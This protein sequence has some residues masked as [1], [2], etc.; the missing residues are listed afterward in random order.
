M[1]RLQ[2]IRFRSNDREKYLGKIRKS[3]CKNTSI[4]NLVT[5]SHSLELET[6][7]QNLV[8]ILWYRNTIV[9]VSPLKFKGKS[10]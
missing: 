6:C 5:Y 7:V 1:N 8:H 3:E 4:L 9:I 2:P 10:S